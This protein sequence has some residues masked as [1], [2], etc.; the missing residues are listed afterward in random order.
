[1]SGLQQMECFGWQKVFLA[2]KFVYSYRIVP[3]SLA[4]GKPFSRFIER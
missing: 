2:A 4:G 3:A 1:M